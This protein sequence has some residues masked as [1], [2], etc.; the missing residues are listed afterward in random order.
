MVRIYEKDPQT[1]SEVIK[2]V[3]KFNAAQQVMVNLTSCTVNVMSID[4]WC[5]SLESHIGHQFPHTQSTPVK[6]LAT[7]PETAQHL[8]IGN[9]SPPQEITFLAVI[10][11]QPQRQITVL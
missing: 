1:L 2:L 11:P 5:F 4:D 10:G 7:S 8:S 9:T 3:K 6:S